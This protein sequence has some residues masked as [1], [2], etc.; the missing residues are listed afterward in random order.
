MTLQISEN[1]NKR[2]RICKISYAFASDLIMNNYPGDSIQLIGNFSDIRFSSANFSE[3]LE[4]NGEQYNQELLIEIKGNDPDTQ[5]TISDLTGKYIILK[6]EYTNKEMKIVG[7]DESPLMLMHEQSGTP[8]VN[9]LSLSRNSA[10]K[11]K[12]PIS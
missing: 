4:A 1:K 2:S 8:L 10:E 12:Y 11:A 7:T 9:K 5:K 6:L 3:I